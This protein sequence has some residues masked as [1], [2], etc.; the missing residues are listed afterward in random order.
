MSSR[1]WPSDVSNGPPP[2]HTE[3]RWALQSNFIDDDESE[4]R[5]RGMCIPHAHHHTLSARPPDINFP[6]TLLNN[7]STQEHRPGPDWDICIINTFNEKKKR[8]SQD[9]RACCKH[10]PPACP[11]TLRLQCLSIGNQWRSPTCCRQGQ[12]TRTPRANKDNSAGSFIYLFPS[13]YLI[14]RWNLSQTGT[15][16]DAGPFSLSEKKKRKKNMPGCVRFQGF[17]FFISFSPSDDLF[18]RMMFFLPFLTPTEGRQSG[19]WLYKM[20]SFT[21]LNQDGGHLWLEWQRRPPQGPG[22]RGREVEGRKDVAFLSSPCE[23]RDGISEPPAAKGMSCTCKRSRCEELILPGFFFFFLA[24]EAHGNARFPWWSDKKRDEAKF[25]SYRY[26]SG[27][28]Q[29]MPFVG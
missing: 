17:F 27:G 15:S 12:Q 1:V 24:S 19:K 4:G 18:R 25:D 21:R 11:P 2:S 20:P 14:C 5:G 13:L 26:L 8:R 3:D 16:Q 7:S 9:V 22:G 29:F 6:M 10:R 28:Q 23:R